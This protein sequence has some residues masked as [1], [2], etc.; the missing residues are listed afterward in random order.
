MRAAVTQNLARVT[1]PIDVVINP[2]KT[3]LET[4]F[5]VLC[6]EIAR[7]FDVIEQ[8]AVPAAAKQIDR[9]ERKSEK[10]QPALR[11]HKPSRLAARRT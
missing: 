6:A 1:R 8:K 2:K 7:A 9:G 3:V 5:Q 4:E 10:D 11:R